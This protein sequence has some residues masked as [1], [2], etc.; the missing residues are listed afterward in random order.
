MFHCLVKHIL[1]KINLDL[2]PIRKI[3][4]AMVEVIPELWLVG[5]QLE[6]SIL[7]IITYFTLNLLLES[8]PLLAHFFTYPPVI[9]LAILSMDGA[10]SDPTDF[11][12]HK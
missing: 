9:T 11:L 3:S 5:D 4:F 7:L 6:A 8:N 2:V 10:L 1:S 12:I